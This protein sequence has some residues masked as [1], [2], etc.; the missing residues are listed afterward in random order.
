MSATPSLHPDAGPQGLRLAVSSAVWGVIVILVGVGSLLAKSSG[1]DAS[2]GQQS[3]LE[4]ASG[5]L[6]IGLGVMFVV[7]GQRLRG[8][9]E[10][11]TRWPA[12]L[13]F[14]ALALQAQIAIVLPAIATTLFFALQGH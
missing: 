4:T 2:K 9:A 8:A 1:V 5:L 11:P 13:G 7:A 12:A 10:N 3:L 14:L 6:T